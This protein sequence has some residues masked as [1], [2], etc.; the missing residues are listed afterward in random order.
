MLDA[1]RRLFLRRWIVP[2][3]AAM[4]AAVVLAPWQTA[5][6]K[7]PAAPVIDTFPSS[8]AA[9]ALDIDHDGCPDELIPLDG[10]VVVS[11]KASETVTDKVDTA[12]TSMSLAGSSNSLGPIT[13]KIVLDPPSIGAAVRRPPG[14]SAPFPIDSFFDVFVAVSLDGA[15]PRTLH[16]S[17][18][19][20]LGAVLDQLPARASTVFRSTL[21]QPVQLVETAS[22]GTSYPDVVGFVL[23][24]STLKKKPT[25]EEKKL[26]ILLCGAEL[27]RLCCRWTL[28]RLADLRTK[29]DA[30]ALST[31]QIAGL[32]TKIDA[33][34]TK[35]TSIETKVNALDTKINTLGSKMDQALQGIQ[36]LL[37]RP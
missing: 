34:D 8:T 23:A 2:T 28:I 30:V 10:T 24:I 1:R 31:D 25:P 21:V 14:P 13:V 19:I 37:S 27:D 15:V 3:V 5:Q 4:G 36:T 12:I 29:L 22:P 7:K 33:L 35:L 18:S 16:A 20:R 11:R 26:E 9:I 17:N 6:A 32:V